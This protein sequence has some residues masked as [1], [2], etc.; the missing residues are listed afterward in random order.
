MSVKTSKKSQKHANFHQ[1]GWR[2]YVG[3]H[4]NEKLI[5]VLCRAD[6]GLS[7]KRL[8]RVGSIPRNPHVSVSE[9]GLRGVDFRR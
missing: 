2:L 4:G 1:N 7:H 8:C 5:K 3:L 9:W 6:V